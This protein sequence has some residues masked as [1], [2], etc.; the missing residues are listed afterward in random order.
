MRNLPPTF[1]QFTGFG[2][3]ALAVLVMAFTRLSQSFAADVPTFFREATPVVEFP[4]PAVSLLP[5]IK[6]LPTA[7]IPR[8]AQLH[9]E[10]PQRPTYDI[11]QYTVQAGDT[12]WSI[13][14][15]FGLR[16]ETI[17]WGNQWI[18]ADAGSLQIGTVLNILPVDGV[19]H[20]AA[21]GDTLERI[22]LLHGTPVEDI[23][24]YPGNDFPLEPPYELTPGQKVIVPNGISQIV[25]QEPGP[26][27][28]PGMGRKSPGLYD[29]ALVYMGTG[30]FLWPIAPPIII[31]QNFWG[32]HPA[33]DLD[34]YYR[35]P[36][37]A[38]DAG[39][40]IFSGWSE[41]GYG[42]LVIIDHG[43]GFWT[44]Y[45]HNSF[46]LVETGQGVL[47]GQQIAESG[48]TGN[49]TGD[50]ID[51]RIRVDG[52]SFLNPLEFLPPIP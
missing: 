16:P 44:Y 46:N 48:S 4:T 42:N 17:L 52:G 31:T 47:Q 6:D 20:I 23:L 39:T 8:L 36:V 10:I 43:N 29:G 18:G 45:A 32:G 22:Q 27:V 5:P 28:V 34:T 37:F 15:K 30:Y 1:L 35:Q 40:V 3:L 21:E 26:K 13:A 12:A 33:L 19:L 51:F 2:L 7:G 41:W 24:S 38:S 14:Q 25:W 11:R 49:S 9:T 50:H